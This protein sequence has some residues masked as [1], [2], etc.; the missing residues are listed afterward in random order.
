MRGAAALPLAV[1][2]LLLAACAASPPL[3]TQR[4]T[5]TLAA[6]YAVAGDTPAAIEVR[7]QLAARGLYAGDAPVAIRAGFAAAPREL[8]TCPALPVDA[9]CKQWLDAP[10]T[11]W[12]PFAPPLRYRLTLVVG[13]GQVVVTKAGDAEDQPLPEMVATALDNLAPRQP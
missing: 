13:N 6:R 1:P 3:A 11:D 9:D 4:D 2:L 12:D 8:G 5:P 7:R 10:E